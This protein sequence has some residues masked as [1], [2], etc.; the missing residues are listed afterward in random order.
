MAEKQARSSMSAS[1]ER[2][3]AG[4]WWLSACS[5]MVFAWL[6]KRFRPCSMGFRANFTEDLKLDKPLGRGYFGEVWRGY[7]AGRTAPVWAVPS[8]ESRDLL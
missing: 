1:F 2:V 5:S 8:L 7:R 4:F 3:L 6:F